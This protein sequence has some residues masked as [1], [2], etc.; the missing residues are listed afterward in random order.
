MSL[1]WLNGKWLSWLVMSGFL[2]K[3]KFSLCW[4]I[5]VKILVELVSVIWKLKWLLMVFKLVNKVG[6]IRCL[7]VCE[8]LIW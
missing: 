1:L 2:I 6:R 7:V 5:V 3:L 4:D 8:V